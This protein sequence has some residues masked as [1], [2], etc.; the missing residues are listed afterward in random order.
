[1]RLSYMVAKDIVMFFR[2]IRSFLFLFITPIFI[3]IL[4]GSVFIYSIPKDIPIMICSEQRAIIFQNSISLL[5]SSDIF[6]MYLED[7]NCREKISDRISR[8]EIRAGIILP[9]DSLNESLL[10]I[11]DNSK[12][13]GQFISSY[14]TIAKHD[15]TQRI[16]DSLVRDILR[17]VENATFYMDM[18]ESKMNDYMNEISDL[19]VK[20]KK[21]SDDIGMIEPEIDKIRAVIRQIN[22]TQLD[23]DSIKKDLEEIKYQVDFGGRAVEE[24]SMYVTFFNLTPFQTNTLRGNLNSLKLIFNE[25]DRVVDIIDSKIPDMKRNIEEVQRNILA[26]TE[27]ILLSIKNQKKVLVESSDRLKAVKSEINQSLK[28]IKIAK[29]Y[30]IKFLNTDPKSYTEPLKSETINFFGEKYFINFIF[31][32]IMI[33]IIMWMA[34][35]LSSISLIRQRSSGILKRISIAPT[36]TGFFLIERLLSNTIIALIPVPLIMLA[37][38]LTLPVEFPSGC[39]IPLI[40]SCSFSA[41]VFV[42]IGLLIAG[43]SRNE[44]TA[45]LASMIVVV[46][47]MFFSGLFYPADLFPDNLKVVSAY[48]PI[49]LGISLLESVLYYTIPINALLVKLG[50]ILAYLFVFTIATWAILRRTMKS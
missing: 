2:D 44:S 46:P 12:P 33:M 21:Y 25:I 29:E 34:V 41:I 8:E 37:A 5:N 10:L 18:F 36:G 30:V 32:G 48:L 42:S 4:I 49:N 16:V 26:P 38:Y 15:I 24:T 3:T 31:P 13:I 50:Y 27:N 43:F 1:M 47:M 19:E 20:L 35:F 23:L 22:D 17:D 39:I 9:P 40:A 45:I 28:N 7:G 14:F 6:K 11:V